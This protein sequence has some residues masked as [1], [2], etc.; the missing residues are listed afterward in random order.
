MRSFQPVWKYLLNR[1]P[2]HLK[3]LYFQSAIDINAVTEKSAKKISPLGRWLIDPFASLSVACGR[4][5]TAA[6][7]NAS[8]M[9]PSSA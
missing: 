8:Q 6:L 5:T 1:G 2:K 4:F 3:G 9:I 7:L